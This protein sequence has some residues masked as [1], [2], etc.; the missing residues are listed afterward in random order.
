M[1]KYIRTW[2]EEILADRW[3]QHCLSHRERRYVFTD[4]EHRIRPQTACDR[5]QPEQ[6]NPSGARGARHFAVYKNKNWS[7]L[8][9]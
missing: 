9:T 6:P 1:D 2:T 5:R 8:A 3:V 7:Q 4:V